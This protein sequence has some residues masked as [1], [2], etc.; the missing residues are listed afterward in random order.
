MLPM[1][2]ALAL[3]Y[4]VHLLLILIV[5]MARLQCSEKKKRP[6]HLFILCL[7]IIAQCPGASIAVRS[8]VSTLPYKQNTYLGLGLGPSRD[9]AYISSLDSALGGPSALLA[10]FG[11]S[12]ACLF[13]KDVLASISCQVNINSTIRKDEKRE[14]QL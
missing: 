5:C 4:F 10:S 3:R 1:L 9:L 2:P 12:S 13:D 8:R 11:Q 6:T 7:I 14:R